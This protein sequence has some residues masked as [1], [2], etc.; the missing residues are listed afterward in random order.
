MKTFLVLCAAAGLGGCAVYP[1][2]GY[3]TYGYDVPPLQVIQQPVYI[4]GGSTVYRSDG[5]RY[6]RPPPP[7][8]FVP[9]PR[10]GRGYGDRDG[11]GIP[12]RVDRN[13]WGYNRPPPPPPVVVVPAPRPGVP[14]VQ[15]PR[16]GRGNGD[17]DGDGIA[18]RADRDRD[19]DGV[20]NRVD[21]DRNNNGVPNRL[22]RS[23]DRDGD[24]ISNRMDP[25]PDI[26]NRR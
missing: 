21:R 23:R 15:A 20:P 6:N 13:P 24:G 10:P 7:V 22:E 9:G 4:Q 3:E 26:P 2:P 17:R 8:F 1:A 19:G 25:R 11:D 14:F 12:N 18:N 16:P 5:Y